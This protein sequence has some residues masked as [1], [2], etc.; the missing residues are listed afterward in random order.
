MYNCISSLKD[1]RI[2]EVAYIDRIL[3][4]LPGIIYICINAQLYSLHQQIPS[5]RASLDWRLSQRF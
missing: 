5:F 2:G 1:Y 3:F 4:T